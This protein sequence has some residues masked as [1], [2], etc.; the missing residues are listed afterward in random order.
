MCIFHLLLL[1]LL[2]GQLGAH[3]VRVD[4]RP[5][6]REV[7]LQ[8]QRA[9]STCQGYPGSSC[10]SD[11][12]RLS[13]LQHAC[14]F[15]AVKRVKQL[16]THLPVAL[17]GAELADLHATGP[18]LLGGWPPTHLAGH[19]QLGVWVT[20]DPLLCKSVEQ[21]VLSPGS[22]QCIRGARGLEAS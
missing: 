4:E 8:T 21:Y 22:L 1:Q 16:H 15:Y 6:Q 3:V 10:S 17:E 9:R 18:A 13:P 11:P 12:C 14:G 5:V 20:L 7:P 19:N 2:L